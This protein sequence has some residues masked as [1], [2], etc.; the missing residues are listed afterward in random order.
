MTMTELQ[1]E[2]RQVGL[3]GTLVSVLRRNIGL[4]V[5]SR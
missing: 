3:T 2:I 4:I 5:A 1:R